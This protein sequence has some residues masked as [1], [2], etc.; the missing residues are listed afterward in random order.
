MA[1]SSDML[2]TA[3]SKAGKESPGH[4]YHSLGS[5]QSQCRCAALAFVVCSIFLV[6]AC[7][8]PASTSSTSLRAAA[9]DGDRVWHVPGGPPLEQVHRAGYVPVN[10]SAENYLFYWFVESK[11]VG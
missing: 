2:L 11:R 9:S 3:E 4:D 5:D 8:L 10:R 6:S 7:F 1:S